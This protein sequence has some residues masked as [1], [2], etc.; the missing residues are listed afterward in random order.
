MK[1]E[2]IARWLKV[3]T[4]GIGI[5]G[6]FFFVFLVP[7]LA[8]EVKKSYPHLAY[9]Y[10]P[11]LLYILVV[12]GAC[13]AILLEFWMVCCQIGKDNS[14][15]MEN[16]EAFKQIS[17]LAVLLAAVWF[18]GAVCL[19]LLHCLHPAL[20]L[21]FIFALF[22]SFAVAICAAA[23]SHLVLKAYQLRQENEL[24]I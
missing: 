2:E 3:I 4:C 23:L 10:W 22:M 17:R 15:S 9:L 14:F 21:F 11:G 7:I 20:L 18:L 8:G 24:T 19:V 5:M 13:F 16:A 12:A 1:Q 6:V